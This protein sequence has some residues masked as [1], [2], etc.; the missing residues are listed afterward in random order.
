[1]SETTEK[2]KVLLDQ[3]FEAVRREER[4]RIARKLAEDEIA[5][6][7]ICPAGESSVYVGCTGWECGG[8]ERWMQYLKPTE[9][10]QK[11]PEEGAEPAE[12]AE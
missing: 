10:P 8:Y 2:Y 4:E 7:V 5:L 9:E 6:G 11:K 1:M 3:K 12:G